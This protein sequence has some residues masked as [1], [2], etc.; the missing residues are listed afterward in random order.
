MP[1]FNDTEGL[2][3]KNVD[4]F[5]PLGTLHY[6]S[7]TFGGLSGL[8]ASAAPL[9]TPAQNGNF[10]VELT[11]IPNN[12]FLYN[13]FYCGNTDGTACAVD[14]KGAVSNPNPNTHAYVR[15]GN[16][17]SPTAA[18]G[19]TATSNPTAT[20]TANGIYFSDGAATPN[21]TNIGTARIEGMLIHHMKITTLGAGS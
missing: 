9:A 14:S 20:S 6:Q 15:W 21:I 4:A 13:N 3:F 7:I 11:R 2:Y 19:T 18:Q 12:T 1:D 8:D 10:V 5:M 16:W 17:A